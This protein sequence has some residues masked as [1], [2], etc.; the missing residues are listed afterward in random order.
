MAWKQPSGATLRKFLS[1]V[2]AG[3]TV[4][5]YRKKQHDL[6]RRSCGRG[7]L[8]REG[9]PQADRRI[10]TWEGGRRRDGWTRRFLRGRMPGRPAAPHRLGRCDDRDDPRT[11]RATNYGRGASRAIGGADRALPGAPA[12]ADGTH[13]GG[14]GGPVVQL[15]RENALRG[16]CTCWPTL[17]RKANPCCLRSAKRRWR[18]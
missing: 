4:L 9:L 2:G 18:K 17:V 12:V 7:L 6:R 8:C 5:P 14:S 1:T 16:C 15:E 13:G 10:T 3:Q 11:A